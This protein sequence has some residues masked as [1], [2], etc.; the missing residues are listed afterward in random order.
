MVKGGRRV[1]LTVS[2]L[3]VN[4]L[5]TKCENLD[6]SQ[7]HVSPWPVTEMSLHLSLH[8]CLQEYPQ[9]KAEVIKVR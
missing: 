9:C 6:V 5:S 4:R 8:T 2:S 1:R 3:S 7:T